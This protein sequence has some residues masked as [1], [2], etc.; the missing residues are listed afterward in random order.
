MGRVWVLDTATKGTGAEMVPLDTVVKKP[1]RSDE[2]RFRLPKPKPREPKPE[3]PRAPRRFRV[4]DVA[5]RAV[6]ADDVGARD[7]L[8]AL[9]DVR[10]FVDVEVFVWE[11]KR[12]RWRLLTLGEQRTLWDRRSAHFVER[13]DDVEDVGEAR[14]LKD[15]AGV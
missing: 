11:P 8:G 4:V 14:D 1:A 7:V 15:Q 3:A 10:S 9:R 6:L 5:T 13:L 12:E 2:P